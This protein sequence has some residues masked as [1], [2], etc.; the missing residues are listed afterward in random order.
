MITSR[1]NSKLKE[2]KKLQERRFRL[3]RNQFAAEGEDLVAAALAHGWE[4]ETIFCADDAP[5]GF[6]EHPRAL[7]VEKHLLADACALGSGARVVGVFKYPSGGP[8]EFLPDPLFGEGWRMCE[9][10]E[11]DPP[12][13]SLRLE[14]ISDP[15]NVGT[16]LRSSAAFAHGRISLGPGCADPYSPKALRAAMGATFAK[17]PIKWI[18]RAPE[19]TVIALDGK[20]DTDIREI[21]PAGPIVLCAGGERDGLGDGILE[22]ADIVARI[23]ML[24]GTESLNVAM[25]VTVALYE[26]SSKLQT[27]VHGGSGQPATGGKLPPD[28]K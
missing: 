4:P 25:A 28:Q 12:E 3:R 5:A 26:L 27:T 11:G 16:I 22:H 7:G 2:L 1:D 8:D 20:G 13:L 18:S 21:V 17:P 9:G 6:T 23:E 10:D 15:G 24:P 19:T 14:G